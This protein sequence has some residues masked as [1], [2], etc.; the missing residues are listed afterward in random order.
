MVAAT[1]ASHP[2]GSSRAAQRKLLRVGKSLIALVLMA[3]FSLS[4]ATAM[5]SPDGVSDVD[6]AGRAFQITASRFLFLQELLFRQ[7]PAAA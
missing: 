4:L 1:P 6:P 3:A 5:F 7:M 2:N